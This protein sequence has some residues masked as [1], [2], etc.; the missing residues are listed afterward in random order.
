[1]ECSEAGVIRDEELLAYLAGEQVRPIVAQHLA[2][3]QRC[4]EQLATYRQIEHSLINKLYRWDCPS[5]QVL[6][7][8]QLGM[9]NN[10]EV[11]AI[12][13][14]LHICVL[15]SGEV[16]VLANFLANDPVLVERIPAASE[17]ISVSSTSNS[18]TPMQHI[19]QTL[20]QARHSAQ[21][22]ARRILA[23]LLSPQPNLAHQMRGGTSLWPRRY[24]A[25]DVSISIQVE[26]SPERKSALQLIGFVSRKGE[27]LAALQGIVV[28]LSTPSDIIST[29]RI[30][31]LGNFIFVALAPATYAL[32]LHFPD[33]IVVI[34][35]LP[36]TEQE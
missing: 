11:A 14:H 32:E 34:E 26:K 35:A 36:V 16:A 1:M 13:S 4:S 20:E 22:S 23:T 30:D 27:A 31:E 18:H 8:Y 28:Q 9:L 21:N 33:G 5:N 17:K 6:G 25:E 2:H 19:Q 10:E 3:C 12:Q 7:E 24:M 29:Q 15:C